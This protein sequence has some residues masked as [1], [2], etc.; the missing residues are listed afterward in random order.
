[1]ESLVEDADNVLFRRVLNNQHNLLHSLL[2]DKS[3]HG[4]DLRRRHHDSMFSHT[5]AA[6]AARTNVATFSV[7]FMCLLSFF[8]VS[9]DRDS[10][11]SDSGIGWYRL[12]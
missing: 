1:V 10:Y 2:P 12:Y 9:G 7:I 8:L 11:G 3:N 6:G 5:D 4:C